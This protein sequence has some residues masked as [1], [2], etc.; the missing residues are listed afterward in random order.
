MKKTI[1]LQ[2]LLTVFALLSLPLGLARITRDSTIPLNVCGQP[3]LFVLLI[4]AFTGVIGL[5]IG[6]FPAGRYGAAVG[7]CLAVLYILFWLLMPK[8]NHGL[9]DP[10]G[11]RQ[12]HFDYVS[13]IK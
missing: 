11:Y 9:R 3:V 1:S 4:A 5:A 7:V 6:G 12:H 2:V 8:P 10:L 13:P